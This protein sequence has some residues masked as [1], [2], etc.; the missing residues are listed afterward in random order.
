[1]LDAV[2]SHSGGICACLIRPFDVNKTA[3]A[4]SHCSKQAGL[5]FT[6]VKAIYAVTAEPQPLKCNCSEKQH[7][8]LK[9]TMQMS[10]NSA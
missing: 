10:I 6:A 8:S 4:I 3:T 1:M 5:L 2:K 7:L 9:P